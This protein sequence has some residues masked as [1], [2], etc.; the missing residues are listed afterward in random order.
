MKLFESVLGRIRV[1]TAQL[2]ID[3]KVHRRS[4]SRFVLFIPWV[5]FRATYG[6]NWSFYWILSWLFK[7]VGRVSQLLISQLTTSLCKYERPNCRVGLVVKSPAWSYFKP[8]CNL[9]V[10]FDHKNIHILLSVQ[11]LLVFHSGMYK[12]I[13]R[14][15]WLIIQ[16]EETYWIC[17]RLFKVSCVCRYYM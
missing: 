10:T 4:F 14:A 1:K 9:V 6:V 15:H 2:A 13:I 7:T 3:F 16:I 5:S 17:I 11:V 12:M 8:L